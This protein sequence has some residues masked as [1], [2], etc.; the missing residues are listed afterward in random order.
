MAVALT[1]SL[2]A[3]LSVA[4]VTAR[5]V[6]LLHTQAVRFTTRLLLSLVVPLVCQKRA[7]VMIVHLVVAINSPRALSHPVTVKDP[8]E[9]QYYTEGAKRIT[10]L[11]LSLVVAPVSHRL[12]HVPTGFSLALPLIPLPHVT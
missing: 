2:L 8:M 7:H 1:S 6:L 5:M 3:P 12:A 11:P 10:F 4:L 9:Q